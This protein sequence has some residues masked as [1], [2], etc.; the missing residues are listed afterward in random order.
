MMSSPTRRGVLL[1]AVML[2]AAPLAAGPS[3]A[4]DGAITETIAA[5]E[6]RLGA[7]VG[8]MIVDTQSGQTWSHRAQERFPLNSTFKAFACAAVLAE[9]DAGKAALDQ[10]ITFTADDL[11]TYSPVTEQRVET[12]MT[13]GE[14]C[15]AAMTTS[16]NT[17][18]N[19]VIESLG[20]PDGVTRFMRQIG[21]AETRLDRTE[22]TLNEAAPGDLRDTTTP[23]AAATSLRELVL[24]DALSPRSRRQLEAWLLGNKVGDPLLRAGL[25][26]DWTIADRTGAGGHGSRSIVAIAWPPERKPVVA[27]IYLTGTEASME[28]RSAAIAEIGTAIARSLP[29]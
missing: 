12:G 27:A 17:A 6:K 21:D 26:K 28:A 29:R 20:G 3:H 7:R 14:I 1:A 11:V 22:P 15:D 9:V 5:V 2:A 25:P 16:D 10:H 24:G 13:L 18:G 19:L 8:A 4:E 23:E